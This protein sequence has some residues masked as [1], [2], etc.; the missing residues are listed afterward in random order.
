[1]VYFDKRWVTIRWD[2]FS[3]AVWVEG[4]AYAEG[5]ELRQS[6]Q[7]I[8]ELFTQHRCSR[9][10]ADNRYLAPISQADQR[11]INEEWFPRMISAGLRYMAVVTARASVTRLSIRQIFSKINGMPLVT[12]N[13]DDIEEARR[14]LRSET[15]P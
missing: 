10:L 13:F 12:A 14:W 8:Y 9:Y 2:E 6:S 1:M 15:G 5:E 11:W 3:R 4:K 7:A